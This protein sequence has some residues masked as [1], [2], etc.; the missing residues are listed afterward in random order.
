MAA[1]VDAGEDVLLYGRHDRSTLEYFRER[2]DEEKSRWN[3]RARERYDHVRKNVIAGIDID[4]F[5]RRLRAVGRKIQS[6]FRRDVV[7]QLLDIA[8]LQH[9]P[10]EMI[11]FL[12]AN[13]KVR[14]RM[15]RNE[16]DGWSGHRVLD[17][18]EE[19]GDRSYWYRRAT[20]GVYR[21]NG[22]GSFTANIYL[23]PLATPNDQLHPDEQFDIMHSWDL[24]DGYFN[25]GGEDPTSKFN[26]KL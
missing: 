16:C 13:P 7:R 22:D 23:D 15:R 5:N 17:H 19:L 21:P 4:D 25:A 26:S 9:P 14:A 18:D 6:S 10:G 12:R 3:S 1:W 24:I 2:A 20:N 11:K 8:D